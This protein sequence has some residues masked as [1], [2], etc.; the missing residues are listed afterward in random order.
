[1]SAISPPWY[2]S[3]LDKGI[4]PDFLMRRVVRYLLRERLSE[5]GHSTTEKQIAEKMAYVERLR[6]RPIAEH[7]DKAN[8]QHYEVST[9]FMKLSLG[10]RMK[11]SCC[12]FPK[13]VTS[14]N[15]AENLMLDLYCQR[16]Q[17]E[18]GMS[19]LDL[20][21][22]WG[23]L[24]L[25][26]CEKFPKANITALSNSSTQRQYIENEARQRGFKNLKVITADVKTHDFDI[27][28]QF[29]RV[30]SI[31]MFEHMKNYDFLLQKTSTWIRPGGLLF[32]HIFCHKQNPYDFIESDGWMSRYF[33][34]GGTMPSADLLLFFSQPSLQFRRYWYLSGEHYAKTSE[35][36]LRNMDARKREMIP[37]L[38]ETYGKGNAAEIWFQRWRVFYIA[39]AEMF[40]YEGGNEW[41]VAHYLFEK[42]K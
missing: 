14:L 33:F 35:A 36:W 4:V 26:L 8:E 17:V 39:V 24:C 21:C 28:E 18:D 29:D 12:Y 5:I 22:G 13:G 20:G 42:S 15:E 40:A 11:Y 23:S 7:T 27:K 1:M 6:E 3:L 25:Y 38:E 9:E 41:G 16:A 30:I 34:T 31:E 2:E 19:I 10:E 32:V 37:Y